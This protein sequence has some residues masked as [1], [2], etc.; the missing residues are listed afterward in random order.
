MIHAVPDAPAVDVAVVDNDGH[1]AVYLAQNLEFGE[2]GP[3]VEVA[4]GTYPVAVFPAGSTN[5]VF[6]PVDVEVRDGEVLTAF[7]EGELSPE[8]DEPGF[9]PVLAYEEAAPFGNGRGRGPPPLTD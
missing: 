4:A 7:A 3:N 6:G 5:A 2:A 9:R 8:G 1:P